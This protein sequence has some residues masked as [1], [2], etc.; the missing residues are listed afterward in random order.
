DELLTMAAQQEIR[1]CPLSQLLPADFS[2][3]PRGK[4]VRGEL[5]GREGWL[6]REELLNSGV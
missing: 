1:F 4:V 3:L 2:A 6:G 5:A